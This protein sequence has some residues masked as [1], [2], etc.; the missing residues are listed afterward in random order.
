M[1]GDGVV[2][3]VGAGPGDPELIS[4]RGLRRIREAD[5][6]VY[7]RLVSN[8]LLEEAPPHAEL[9]YAG[10]RVGGPSARQEDINDILVD[11]ARAG[12]AVVRLKGGD[13]FVF[14][15]GGEEAQACALADV[16]CEIVPGISS[17]VGV[18]TSAGIPVTRRG[19]AASFAVVSAQRADEAESK[20]AALAGAETLVIMMGVAQLPQIAA[21]LVRDHRS[22]TTPVAVIERGTEPE[23]RVVVGTLATI[24]ELAQREQIKSPATIVVGDVVNMRVANKSEARRGAFAELAG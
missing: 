8:A 2:Y 3:L 20:L 16:R 12:D 14:G 6:V 15:R 13:P 1:I 5:V 18:P 24:G 17:A 4:V 22:P 23:E 10:K 9:V 11:R 7:D 19:V 21:L